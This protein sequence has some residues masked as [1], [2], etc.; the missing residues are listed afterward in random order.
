MLY[1]QAFAVYNSEDVKVNLI[2]SL[3]KL[4]EAMKLLERWYLK[5]EA[6]K[7]TKTIHT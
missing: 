1:S 7:D 5:L 3:E 6:I 4:F 2:S